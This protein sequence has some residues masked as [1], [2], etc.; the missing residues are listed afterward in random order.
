M[1]K[2][3]ILKQGKAPGFRAAF[4]IRIGKVAHMQRSLVALAWP[5]QKRRTLEHGT[6]LGQAKSG[7]L[8]LPMLGRPPLRAV[9]N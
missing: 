5:G 8:R 1:W 3:P 4:W 2:I 6:W 7:D 9:G